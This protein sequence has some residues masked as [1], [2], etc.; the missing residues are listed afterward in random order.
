M[1][2]TWRTRSQAIPVALSLIAAMTGSDLARAADGDGQ[3]LPGPRFLD[4]R[5]NED[6]S[7][8]DGEAG[9]YREDLFDPIKHIH[10]T[11]DWTLSIG[12]EF[13]YRLESETNK[14]FGATEPAQ[15]TFHL[16]RL[17][18]HFDAKYKDWLRV[19][20][21]GIHA[22]DEE[23]D[24]ALRG[25]D[26][27]RI[28][29]HQA[30]VD[31]RLPG[32]AS[33]W[34]VRLGRQELQYGGQ[35]LVSGFTWGNVRRRFD[36]VKMFTE[37]EKWHL[38]FWYAK[39]VITER[40]EGD[41]FDRLVDFY[42]AYTTYKG[43][44]RHGLDLYAFAIDDRGNRLNPNARRGDRNIYTLGTR[45]WG[46][47]NNFDYEAELSG[48][49][50]HWARD[51]VQAWSWALDGGYTV[52]DCPWKSRLGAGFDWAS[53]DGDPFD[54]TVGTFTQLFPL[55]HQYFGFLDLV[56]RQNITAVNANVSAW[57]VPEKVKARIAYH[58]FWLTEGEDAVYNAGGGAGRRDVSGSSGKELGNEVDLT[59]QWIFN[60]HESVLVGWSHFF[61]RDFIQRT[62]IHK[63]ADLLYVQY[64][65][66][67]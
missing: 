56:G 47:T 24:L 17:L 4:L 28:D 29:L 44:E 25:T 7:Y 38:A 58:V 6:F 11:D 49:W 41:D 20:V 36:A 30:F 34:T 2:S 54:K 59:M 64:S 35:R 13:R 65:M 23:R 50:G 21:Q 10:L 8:L 67:F 55:G 48:Q 12:G 16:F 60:A 39:E 46:K 37:G 15:D 5:W 61:D 40:K 26:E 33:D 63:D 18:L 57:P 42:G 66:K 22:F 62:G 3:P 32:T 43:M 51:T 9:T 31:V 19:F 27:N 53:G 45:F 14:G 1:N 52:P